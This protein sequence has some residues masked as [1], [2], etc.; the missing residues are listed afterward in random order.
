MEKLC[1][2]FLAGKVEASNF[3]EVGFTLSQMNDCIVLDQND[4]TENLE[5]LPQNELTSQESTHMCSLAGK[6]N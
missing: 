3:R 4:Y 5:L 1:R 2:R 6:L